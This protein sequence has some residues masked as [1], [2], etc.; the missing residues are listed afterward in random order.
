MHGVFDQAAHGVA[1]LQL[2][3][4]WALLPTCIGRE[5]AAAC[6]R[7]TLG[8]I[9]EFR[10]GAANGRKTRRCVAVRS[11]NAGAGRQQAARIRVRHV[12]E[13]LAGRSAFYH[14]ASI[15]HQHAV[16]VLRDHAQVVRDEDQRHAALVHQIGDEVEDLLLHGDVE[17]GGGFVRNQQLGVAGQ[18][19]GNGDAL[20]LAAGELVRIRIEALRRMRNADAVQQRQCRLAR[21]FCAE[22]AVQAQRL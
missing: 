3:R 1:R 14:G 11:G 9:D 17:R 10:H 4:R 7:T 12:V 16:H 13:H 2:Q 5:I 18:S 15:H 21:L 20:A 19:H 22:L 8:Q 6:K